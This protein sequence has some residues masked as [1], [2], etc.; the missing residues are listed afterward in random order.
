MKINSNNLNHKFPF[1]K[2]LVQEAKSL[3][4]QGFIII[5]NKHDYGFASLWLTHKAY[6]VLVN[7]GHTLEEVIIPVKTEQA[8]SLGDHLE[9]FF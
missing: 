7:A 4:Q 5:T 2:E 6:W 3:I 8:N 1:S 9:I